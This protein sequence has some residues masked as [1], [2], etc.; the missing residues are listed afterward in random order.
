M[1]LLVDQNLSRRL[2]AAVADLYP[3]SMH[4]RDLKMARAADTDIWDY[5]KENGFIIATKDIWFYQRSLVSGPPAKVIWIRTGNCSASRIEEL[6]RRNAVRL[7]EFADD[8]QA[9]YIA[10]A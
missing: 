3:G 1:K 7:R 10:L 2:P 5:A 9:A 4:V 8:E 6:L